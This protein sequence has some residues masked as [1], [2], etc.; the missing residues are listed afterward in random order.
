MI[1]NFQQYAAAVCY[2]RLLKLSFWHTRSWISSTRERE[3]DLHKRQQWGSQE[4][5][6]KHELTFN[7]QRV[8]HRKKQRNLMLQS[9]LF[10]L[11]RTRFRI[12]RFHRVSR[13][14]FR[15][16]FGCA[17]RVFANSGRSFHFIVGASHF[18]L[19]LECLECTSNEQFLNFLEVVSFYNP[20]E[21][22]KNVFILFACFLHFFILHMISSFSSF[23]SPS[24]SVPHR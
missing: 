5:D 4:L 13:L 9:V 22:K 6:K 3:Q 17:W 23:F 15:L 20:G 11:G 14:T 7:E 18:H 8:F 12:S 10:E 16:F 21:E 24:L 2:E 19:F 1:G